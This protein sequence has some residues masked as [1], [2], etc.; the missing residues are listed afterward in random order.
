MYYCL[1]NV[2]ENQLQITANDGPYK[3]FSICYLKNRKTT[4]VFD[5]KIH[6]NTDSNQ[7]CQQIA[8]SPSNLGKMFFWGAKI[9]PQKRLSVGIFPGKFHKTPQQWGP[10]QQPILLP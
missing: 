4:A 2:D 3:F 8:R 7:L 5:L 10:P 1:L 6:N 9:I